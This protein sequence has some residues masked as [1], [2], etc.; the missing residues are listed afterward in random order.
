V[1]FSNGE[2]EIYDGDASKFLNIEMHWLLNVYRQFQQ[3]AS[4][5]IV[6]PDGNKPGLVM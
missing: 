2:I 3:A 4:S 1:Y 6:G 5:N